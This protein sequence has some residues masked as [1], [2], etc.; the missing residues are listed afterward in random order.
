[1]K[2]YV[3]YKT[4]EVRGWFSFNKVKII[5]FHTEESDAQEF[6]DFANDQTIDD[7]RYSYKVIIEGE[8]F[9]GD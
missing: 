9:D 1:M 5:K 3:V 7:V 2:I 8:L 6:V 4:T